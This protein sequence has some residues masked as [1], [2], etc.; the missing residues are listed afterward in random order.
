[1]S[2]D[3]NGRALVEPQ[4]LRGY[5]DILPEEMIFQGPLI[6]KIRKVLESYGFVPLD[7]PAVE[8]LT[9]LLGTSGEEAEKE[10]IRF[11]SKEGENV[12]LRYDLTVPFARLLAQYPEQLRLPFR[13]Y[14]L[15]PVFRNDKPE[16]GRFRQFRQFDFDAAGSNLVAVDAEIVAVMSDIFRAVGLAN[17][18]DKRNFTIHVNNRKLLEA[19]LSSAGVTTVEKQRHVL[20]VVDKL[21]KI[22]DEDVRRELA[23]GRID[24][25]G[26]KIPGVGL[27]KEAI[28]KLLDLIAITGTSRGHV[29]ENATAK[30]PKDDVCNAA[31]QEMREL[32]AALTSLGVSE[33]DAIFDV[34]LARG[35]AYYT[36][37]IFEAYLADAPDIGA[38]IGGGRYDNLVDRFLEKSIPAVGASFGLDR[39]SAALRRLKLMETSPTLV[40]AMVIS[41]PGVPA[42]YLLKVASMLRQA[43]IRTEVYF[44]EPNAK[45][46]DQLSLANIREVPVAV[47]IG[48]DEMEKQQA[49]VKDLQAGL[50]ARAAVGDR[51][52]FRKQGKTG[53]VTVGLDELVATVKGILG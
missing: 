6:E 23:G 15:A 50:Q 29:V 14:Q 11:K 41:F 47:I 40:Q 37:P 53:Q 16:E 26:S 36:G 28:D 39:F 51:E 34:S 10:I 18:A 21:Q 46:K 3:T 5:R 33:Q 30:L 17:S 8:F 13:R 12:G 44:G 52:E 32:D 1:M 48:P 9:T 27:E 24:S 45:M 7:T 19:M 43:D 35:L 25:S 22:G 20:R 4:T 42:P 2:T 49:S 38:V 31:L